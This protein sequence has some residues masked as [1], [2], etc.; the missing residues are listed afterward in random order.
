MV[1]PAP[2][3]RREGRAPR[4]LLVED[5][6]T[7]QVVAA[8][9]LAKL[10]YTIDVAD[11]GNAAVAAVRMQSYDAVLMDLAMPEMDGLAATHA[12]RALPP[13]KGR[14]PIIALTANAMLG[15]SEEY[16]AA[17]MNDYVSKPIDASQ[18]RAKLE[19]LAAARAERMTTPASGTIRAAGS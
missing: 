16:L 8:A 6:R 1:M 18:L 2:D 10:G 7:N 5:D 14:V 19:R 3:D 17:G 4:L 11:D 13:P 12:I 9:L 15:A